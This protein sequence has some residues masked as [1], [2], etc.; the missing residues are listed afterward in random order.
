MPP[1]VNLLSL[2]L[3]FSIPGNPRKRTRSCDIAGSQLA[4]RKGRNRVSHSAP[5]CVD[6]SRSQLTGC[7]PHAA[8]HIVSFFNQCTSSRSRIGD[9]LVQLDGTDAAM[10]THKQVI[11]YLRPFVTTTMLFGV[12]KVRMR[13]AA[14][15]T[16][17]RLVPFH[18]GDDTRTA[19]NLRS[20]DSKHKTICFRL[21]RCTHATRA[22][23]HTSEQLT[24]TQL[25]TYRERIRQLV[26]QRQLVRRWSASSMRSAASLALT[27]DAPASPASP[28]LSPTPAATNWQ[29]E[30][31]EMTSRPIARRVHHHDGA[32]GSQKKMAVPS[33]G[34]WPTQGTLTKNKLISMI[35]MDDISNEEERA[36]ERRAEDLAALGLG[37]GTQ[38]SGKAV[39]PAAATSTAAR[40]AQLAAP[41]NGTETSVAVMSGH[42]AGAAAKNPAGRSESRAVHAT[43]SSGG[44]QGEHQ[45]DGNRQ[46]G[47][48]QPPTIGTA[49]S[50][51][52]TN[53]PVSGSST[54]SVRWSG[55][56]KQILSLDV[57]QLYQRLS[58][59]SPSPTTDDGNV[60]EREGASGA[61]IRAKS[62][63][64]T[65]K[66][67]CQ[68]FY[69]RAKHLRLARDTCAHGCGGSVSCYA[70]PGQQFR[71]RHPFSRFLRHH[72][73]FRQR[74]PDS[75]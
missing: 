52:D 55:S 75:S 47:A 9:V 58:A 12:I 73:R 1:L 28:P 68:A 25:D 14:A 67:L 18:C 53:T 57:S 32:S 15:V 70:Y 10:L 2:F 54:S 4:S 69:R 43:F 13:S 56:V 39:A 49:A 71:W 20:L 5:P 35:L 74:H 31:E 63:S 7:R 36:E 34:P 44:Q 40:K 66:E 11:E 16:S 21:S 72:S 50:W 22:A 51:L 46:N 24:P 29:D 6:T 62:G 41:H 60:V 17:A 38:K 65:D 27:L 59:P 61:H 64:G 48:R 37:G 42:S 23:P 3:P 8:G 19:L 26:Q 33:V 45:T 30:P